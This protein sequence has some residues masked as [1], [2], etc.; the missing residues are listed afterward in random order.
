MP[1]R[2]LQGLVRVKSDSS[3][4][5]HQGYSISV[6]SLLLNFFLR[7]EFSGF[8]MLSINFWYWLNTILWNLSRLSLNPLFL[9]FSSIQ[10]KTGVLL[11]RL[12]IEAFF[13]LD[14]WSRP[15]RIS[16]AN[17]PASRPASCSPGCSPPSGRQI[18]PPRRAWSAWACA[19]TARPSSDTPARSVPYATA[20][21]H[22]A[23][24]PAN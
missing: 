23:P 16:P 22:T 11:L 1:P 12:I 7:S 13:V 15:L 18:C 20:P 2:L 19:C 21:N 6:L 8:L 3:C 5:W 9:S 24:T 17:L 10:S 14:W 4:Y